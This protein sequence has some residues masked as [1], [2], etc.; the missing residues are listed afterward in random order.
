MGLRTLYMMAVAGGFAFG[1]WAGPLERD[2]VDP[3]AAWVVHVDAEALLRS[4][5]GPMLVKKLGEGGP[6]G[7]GDLRALGIDPVRDLKALTVF[8][9]SEWTQGNDDRH[10]EDGVAIV[11]ATAGADAMGAALP[12]A[13]LTAYAVSATDGVPVHSW[14]SEGMGTWF[15]AVT[16]GT[17]ADERR[18]VFA[19]RRAELDGWIQRSKPARLELAAR[20][21]EETPALLDGA[22]PRT[23]SI[24]FV[25]ARGIRERMG[26]GR[27]ADA[28]GEFAKA[29]ESL[30]LDIASVPGAGGAEELAAD[31]AVWFGDA[32]KA[33]QMTQIAQ[34]GLAMLRVTMSGDPVSKGASDMLG[35]VRVESEGSKM[36]VSARMPWADV[37]AVVGPVIEVDFAEAAEEARKAGAKTSGEAR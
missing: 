34:G 7:P 24:L 37:M 16:P 25:S 13:G 2:V 21:D 18:V 36:T 15:A 29:A 19:S 31:A 33:T 11:T 5:M 22:R 30:T 35:R 32:E 17:N 4:P 14:R 1:A 26:K 12:E 3:R 9:R 23:G 6:G 28:G 20:V 27:A 10:D 8:G